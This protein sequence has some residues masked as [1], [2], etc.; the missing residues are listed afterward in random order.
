MKH[1][2]ILYTSIC[3]MFF[4]ILTNI[5]LLNGEWDGITMFLCMSIFTFSS[6]IYG[7]SRK[8]E[9][10]GHVNGSND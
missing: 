2:L 4:I 3:L 8:E 5:T 7:F 10:K 9:K 1:T 6:V